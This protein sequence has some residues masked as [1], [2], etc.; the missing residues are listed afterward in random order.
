MHVDPLALRKIPK[1]D[2]AYRTTVPLRFQQQPV[3][4]KLE[5]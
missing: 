4:S 2:G 1:E 3:A 5:Q